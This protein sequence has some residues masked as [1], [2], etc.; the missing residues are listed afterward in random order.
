[1]NLGFKHESWFIMRLNH[2]IPGRFESKS[3]ALFSIVA[4]SVSYLGLKV[5]HGIKVSS[6][7]KHGIHGHFDPKFLRIDR[8]Y[9]IVKYVARLV[10]S[11]V[12]GKH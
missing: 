2:T 6:R 1:M 9:I 5:Q 4:S 11:K 10:R 7:F 12:H 8:R 3:Y